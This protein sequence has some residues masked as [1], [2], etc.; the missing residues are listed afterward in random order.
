[1][2][3]CIP[4]TCWTSL[5]VPSS[6]TLKMS[7][8]SPSEGLK[9]ELPVAV[10]ATMRSRFGRGGSFQKLKSRKWLITLMIGLLFLSI[11]LPLSEGADQ[12]VIKGEK[13]KAMNWRK[14]R[15]QYFKVHQ[16]S[17]L[18][19]AVKKRFKGLEYFPFNPDYY[20]EGQINRKIFQINDPKYYATFLTNKGTSKRYIRY[21]QFHFNLAGK[22]YG[23]EVYKSI[24][25]DNLFI[26]FKDL[27]NGRETYQGGRYI[28]AEI[29]PGYKMILDFNMAYYPSCAY[30]DRFTCALPP[31]ENDLTIEIKAGE[32]N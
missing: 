21:G 24:L 7:N 3:T 20:F 5:S 12:D 9:I 29:L 26:P 27:T 17:P 15:D 19:P 13:E 14:E 31:R 1:M 28:D 10:Y 30:N 4:D 2:N 18:T 11:R 25:S 16:R 22:D 6:H 23:L 32:R 8:R